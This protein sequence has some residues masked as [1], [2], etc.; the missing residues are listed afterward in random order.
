MDHSI[1]E[2]EKRIFTQDKKVE[3]IHKEEGLDEDI[4]Y[5]VSDAQSDSNQQDAEKDTT[6]T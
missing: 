6:E 1:K 4:K 3:K 5:D 2:E